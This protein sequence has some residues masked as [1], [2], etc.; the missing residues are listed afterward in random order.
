M[1]AIVDVSYN[2]TEISGPGIYCSCFEIKRKIVIMGKTIVS[3]SDVNHVISTLLTNITKCHPEL[4]LQFGNVRSKA[5]PL[6]V[7]DYHE[8]DEKR[9]KH[10]LEVN[11]VKRFALL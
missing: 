6:Y 1:E 11:V 5:R 10:K 8:N 9:R 7:C 3:S 4:L 2:K